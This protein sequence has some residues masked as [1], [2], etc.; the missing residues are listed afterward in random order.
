MISSRPAVQRTNEA[1]IKAAAA[2]KLKAT[3]AK[4][5][6]IQRNSARLWVS[7]SVRT[8]TRCVRP[9]RCCEST[10]SHISSPTSTSVSSARSNHRLHPAFSTTRSTVTA[11]SV[12]STVNSA[13]RS[14][15]ASPTC[16]STSTSTAARRRSSA[17]SV[18][19][20]VAVAIR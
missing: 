15:R 2:T 14:S 19:S 3:R 17:R 1:A 8:V 12:R 18:R 4:P 20:N 16:A 5:Q 7:S 9:S 6:R 13:T 10:P 11:K